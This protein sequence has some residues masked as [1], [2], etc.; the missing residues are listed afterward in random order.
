MSERRCRER[1]APCAA[2][3]LLGAAIAASAGT[4][5]AD[6]ANSPG[7]SVEDIRDIR[8]PKADSP[9]W[10]IPAVIAG[11]GLV[12]LAGYAVWRRCRGRLAPDPSAL[13]LAERR[14]EEIRS[15]MTPPDSVR[16]AV[17]ISAVVREYIEHRFEVGATQLTTEEFLRKMLESSEAALARQR[18]LLSEFLRQ[19]DIVKFADVRL[20]VDAMD[21]LHRSALVFVREAVNHGDAHDSLPSP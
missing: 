13:E 12:A 19:C 9:G 14:L 17:E 4:G 6:G 21:S 20:T 16:F 18:A 10:I 3:M 1:G 7:A 15:L 11:A 8:G 5:G 2:K